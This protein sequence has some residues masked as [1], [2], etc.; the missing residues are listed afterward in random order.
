MEPYSLIKK[1]T[2]AI[3][4]KGNYGTHTLRKTWGYIERVE[5]GVPIELISKRLNHSNVQTTMIY[6][7]IEDKEVHKILMNEIG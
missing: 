2:A 7:C 5:Y 3:N 6:C 1:W 4:L